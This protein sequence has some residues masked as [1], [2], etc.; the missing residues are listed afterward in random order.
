MCTDKSAVSKALLIASGIRAD[1]Y[2]EI[3]GL[4]I[5]DSESFA[6]WNGFFRGLKAR[7]LHGVD[8]AVSDN[9]GASPPDASGSKRE[10]G[11]K[12]HRASGRA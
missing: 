9:W 7:G 2:R 12:V 6:T 11:E 1:G 5:G 8:V 10:D 3:L 4:S